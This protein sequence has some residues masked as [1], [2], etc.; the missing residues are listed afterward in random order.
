MRRNSRVAERAA[1]GYDSTCPLR[2]SRQI[3]KLQNIIRR[4]KHYPAVPYDKAR[5]RGYHGEVRY[6]WLEKSWY[7]TRN[8]CQSLHDVA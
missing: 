1:S 5:K 3:E 2:A 7:R 8:T 6:D 4:T